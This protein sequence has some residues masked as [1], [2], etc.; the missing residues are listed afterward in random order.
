MA[1]LVSYALP[2]LVIKRGAQPAL[3]V[4]DKILATVSVCKVETV[5]DTTAAGDSFNAGYL[6]ARYQN[7]DPELAV[8]A[9]ARCAAAVIQHRGAIVPLS[10]YQTSLAAL[11]IDTHN[12]S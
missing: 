9:G 4:R 10:D 12:E 2:E 6:A 5:V 7:V 11:V 1:R 8:G 3:V